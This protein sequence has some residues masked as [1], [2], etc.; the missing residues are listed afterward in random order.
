MSH[1]DRR[2]L[3]RSLPAALHA[4]VV[5][6][7]EVPDEAG[8]PAVVAHATLVSWA[9]QV[10][11]E[12]PLVAVALERHGVTL[13][14][15]E[16]A[17]A[18]TLAPLRAGDAGAVALARRIGRPGAESPEKDVGLVLAATPSG[19]PVPADAVTGWL[20]CRVRAV[21]PAGDH[22]LVVAAVV[23]AATV[24]GDLAPLTAAA[25]GWSYAG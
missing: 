8:A 21:H 13:P 14:L 24:H 1:D 2:R 7:A 3:L 12:P 19:A 11:F 10:S 16:R 15:V 18:F 5:R 9:M 6:R 20:E 25:A 4:L 23:D 17:G 22:A